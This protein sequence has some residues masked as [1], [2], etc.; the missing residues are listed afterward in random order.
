M[1]YNIGIH[2]LGINWNFF[3]SYETIVM[4]F[5]VQ[6]SM[7]LKVIE[8]KNVIEHKYSRTKHQLELFSFI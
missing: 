3:I 8:H 4:V 1:S 6:C 7:L 2:G 5:A